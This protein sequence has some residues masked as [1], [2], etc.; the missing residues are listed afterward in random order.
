MNTRLQEVPSERYDL[1][2]YKKKSKGVYLRECDTLTEVLFTHES[3]WCFMNI[4]WIRSVW[5]KLFWDGLSW[6]KP[7]V[8][9]KECLS[10]QFYSKEKVKNFF[11]VLENLPAPRYGA[12]VWDNSMLRE[13][14]FI[15]PRSCH[16]PI[17]FYGVIPHFVEEY[18]YIVELLDNFK[19]NSTPKLKIV[20]NGTIFER[21][22]K[23]NVSTNWFRRVYPL[24]KLNYDADSL[25]TEK[26]IVHGINTKD[27]E[28]F[29]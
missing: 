9:E 14:N 13:D 11:W 26:E 16:F 17:P 4:N 21:N 28:L 7:M 10:F 18:F 22:D 1:T 12:V 25:L 19:I 6:F 23:V 20:D 15:F 2:L 29:L 24:I 3:K 5:E 27:W 8:E